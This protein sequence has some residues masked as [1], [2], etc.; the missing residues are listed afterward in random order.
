[1]TVNHSKARAFT[2]LELLLVI[3]IMIA[4]AGVI[5]PSLSTRQAAGKL[6]STSEQLASLMSLA[7]GGAMSKGCSYRCVF[8][9]DGMRAVIEEEADPLNHPGV[10]EPIKAHWAKLD[11]GKDDIRCL[12]VH[13]D[14]WEGL[15]KEEEAEILD[16]VDS[17]SED[18]A[19]PPILFYPDGTSDTATILLGDSENNNFTLTLNGITGQVKLERGNKFDSETIDKLLKD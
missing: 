6:R 2:L 14:E 17:K 16:R 5:W 7:R 13:F 11:L 1:M 12:S 8:E 19:S 3:V 18:H 15:L 4:L 10:F 9:V